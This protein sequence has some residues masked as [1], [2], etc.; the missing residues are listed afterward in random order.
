MSL[1]H[2][3]LGLLVDRPASGYD[4]MKLF[5]DSLANV[6]PA[7]QSQMYGELG[8]MAAAGL[9]DVSAEGPRRRKEYTLTDQGLA[10]LREWMSEPERPQPR[11]S[12]LL[13]KVFFL[14]VA[15]AEQARSLFGNRA[16]LAA[17]EHERLAG[18]RDELDRE[19]GA[20]STNGRIALEYGLR[21]AAMEKE[22]AEWAAGQVGGT[23]P[24]A[25]GDAPHGDRDTPSPT[26]RPSDGGRT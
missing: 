20:L 2:A 21:L 3:L 4:L 25:E 8:R 12:R 10:E 7:T 5:D 13:L 17:S 9:V 15:T 26:P 14:N 22:W 16:A 1:R 23:P 19:V 11:R 18:I 6:W 24:A